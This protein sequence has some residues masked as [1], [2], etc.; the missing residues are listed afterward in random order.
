MKNVSL[1]KPLSVLLTLLMAL[2][3]FAGLNV[4][5][6]AQAYSAGDTISFGTYPQTKVTDENLI[7][8][9][10][11]AEKT[12]TSYRYYS[13]TGGSGYDGLQEPG[14]WMRFADFFHAGEKYRAVTFDL[15]RPRWLYWK[16]EATGRYVTQY[17]DTYIN[18]YRNNTVYYFKYEPLVWRVLDPQTGLVIT[19]SIIDSQSLCNVIYENPNDHKF[20][21]GIDSTVYSNDYAASDLRAWMNCQ[22]YATAFS[23]GQKAAILTTDVETGLSNKIFYLSRTQANNMGSDAQRLAYGTDYAKSQGLYVNAG[24]EG[25]GASPWSLRTP[26]GSDGS[27]VYQVTLTKGAVSIAQS[28]VQNTGWGVRLACRME[29][30]TQDTTVSGF[31]LSD[32]LEAGHTAGEAKMEN[33]V[34][35]TC[36][37][38]GSYVSVVYCTVCGGELS[39]EPITVP[40]TG[41]HAWEWVTDVAPGCASTGIGHQKCKNCTAVQNEGTELPATGEHT[42]GE[43]NWTDQLPADCGNDGHIG[44]FTC[45]GC[46]QR[47][48]PEG[49]LLTDDDIVIPATGDHAWQ[50][51]PDE[52]PGCYTDGSQHQYCTVCGQT[53]NEGTPIP[54]AHEFEAWVDAVAPTC[55]SDGALGY[56]RCHV[57]GDCFDADGSKLDSI[58]DPA[59]GNHSYEDAEW[60]YDSADRHVRTCTVCG[61]GPQY[62]DHNVIVKGGGDATCTDDGYTGDEFCS[63]CGQRLSE[64]EIIPAPGHKTEVVNAKAPTAAEDGYTGDEV[65]T[66]C[67][68]TIKPGEVIPAT[69]EQTE[70]AEESGACPVCGKTHNGG[71]IDKLIGFIHSLIAAFRNLFP[72]ASSVC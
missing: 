50:W 27:Y 37:R 41:E 21:R 44:Y 49:K 4:F 59:T 63:V 12:W 57:C 31:L 25:V 20:Y 7:A 3:V 40:A 13:G 62:E 55:G 61:K 35:A 19:E 64:G 72:G 28:P 24:G 48:D 22:F 26:Y 17:N 14:D 5:P 38:D 39:R 71:V 32:H 29:S 66:V 45:T 36:D 23:D 69:G 30:L 8:E 6:Q 70:P 67:G 51:I 47:F 65:C 60:T 34:D 56:Q 10:D 43:G 18:G 1:R 33:K 54:A 9:L 15:Y 52:A 16:A 46:G 11:A 2:S 53:Q 68:Q 42:Y 58:V